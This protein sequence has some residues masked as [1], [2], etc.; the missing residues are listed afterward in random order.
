M[1][2]L[3]PRQA[4]LLRSLPRDERYFVDTDVS[5]MRNWDAIWQRGYAEPHLRGWHLT[6]A[7]RSLWDALN[8]EKSQ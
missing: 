1:P 5:P 8:K 6:P 4:E 7:G 3:T 2:T